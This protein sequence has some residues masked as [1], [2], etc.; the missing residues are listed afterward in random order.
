LVFDDYCESKSVNKGTMYLD[1]SGDAEP[2]I[3]KMRHVGKTGLFVPV[4]DNGGRLYRVFEDKFYAVSGTKDH[5]WVE[6]EGA[7]E[8]GERDKLDID[9]SYFNKLKEDA[10]KTIEKFG[11]FEEFVAIP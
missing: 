10:I 4:L 7:V 6:A 2:D 8:L 9:M 11:S 3:S 1:K 5:L